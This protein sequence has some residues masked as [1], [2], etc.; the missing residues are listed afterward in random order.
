MIDAYHGKLERAKAEIDR[1]LTIASLPDHGELL[2]Q[3]LLNAAD[4]AIAGG[5]PSDA[6]RLL[7]KARSTL[8]KAHPPASDN[9]WRYAVWDSVNA[10]LTGVEGDRPSAERMLATAEGTLSARFGPNGF[11][12]VR[13]ERTR[14][15]FID[16][17]RSR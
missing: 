8:E 12:T 5:N 16:T 13:A 15:E 10:R 3:V 17:P 2:D 11:Y 1:A 9:V 6:R 14:Q 4:L 7:S